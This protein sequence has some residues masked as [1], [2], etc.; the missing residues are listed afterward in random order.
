MNRGDVVLFDFPFS[1]RTG[2]KLRPA[3]VVQQMDDCLKIA[4]GLP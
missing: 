2:S 4:L 3:A 1:D